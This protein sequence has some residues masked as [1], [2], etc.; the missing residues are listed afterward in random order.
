[1]GVLKDAVQRPKPPQKEPTDLS[2]WEQNLHPLRA[3]L[4]PQL[5]LSFL[6]RSVLEDCFV[7]KPHLLVPQIE[8]EP[9]RGLLEGPSRVVYLSTPQV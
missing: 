7:A 9:E 3:K 2:Q 5:L 8:I 1:M 4:G 6:L